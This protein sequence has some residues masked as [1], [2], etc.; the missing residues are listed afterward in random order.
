[1]LHREVETRFGIKSIIFACDL[2]HVTI[3]NYII[4]LEHER[5]VRTC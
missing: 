1:M 5:I 2:T 3:N 4:I